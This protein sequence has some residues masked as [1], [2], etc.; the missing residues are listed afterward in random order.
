MEGLL[1]APPTGAGCRRR[2]DRAGLVGVRVAQGPDDVARRASCALLN[3]LCK[4]PAN[5]CTLTLLPFV[6][7][8]GSLELPCCYSQITDTSAHNV[9]GNHEHSAINGGLRGGRTRCVDI[10][11]FCQPMFA[12]DRPRAGQVLIPYSKRKLAFRARERRSHNASSADA[13]LDRSR[14]VQAW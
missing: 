4:T 8:H 5:Q 14:R 12:G 7:C 10:S 1:E 2:S 3:K 11:D 9:I 13:G 6:D